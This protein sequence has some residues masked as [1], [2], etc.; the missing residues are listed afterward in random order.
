MSASTTVTSLVQGVY[1]F[2]LKV[3]DNKGATAVDTVQVTVTAANIPPAA[4]AGTD[5]AINL[6][7][8][9]ATLAGGGTDQDGRIRQTYNWTKISG[10]ATFNIV[11][12]L[13][14]LTDVSGLVQGIYQFRLAVTDN[15]GATASD[16]VQV[17]VNAPVNIVPTAE[18]GANQVFNLPKNITTLVGSGVD[19][20]GVISSYKWTEVSGP[21]AV[22]V[23]PNVKSTTVIGLTQGIYKF[24]LEVT[25]NKGAVGS[26]SV[27]ITVNKS[28]NVSPF[29]SLAFNG[30]LTGGNV[31]VNKNIVYQNF[32]NPF[33]STT[34][35]KYHVADNAPVKIIVFNAMGFQ[36][37]VLANEVKIRVL[38]R[39]NGMLPI[40]H[41]AT[42]TIQ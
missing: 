22:I 10:P 11:N 15:S 1:R 16:T 42:I 26:D 30:Q 40:F 29:G 39:F 34:T 21:T 4:N 24:K 13:S 18:A 5:Q 20:D 25:D 28:V 37:A 17:A 35:I 8:N 3:F 32:P 31:K 14:P 19:P 33:T 6:P 36:V 7:V 38:I 2:Q 23:T 41:R 27:L 9:V 12:P